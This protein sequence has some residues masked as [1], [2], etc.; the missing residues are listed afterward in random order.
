MKPVSLGAGDLWLMLF[1]YL[2]LTGHI[3]WSWW[4]I[5]GIAIILLALEL[6]RVSNP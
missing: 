2:K 5:A 1:V 6:I 3:D 4:V